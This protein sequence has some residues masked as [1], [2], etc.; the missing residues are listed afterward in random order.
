MTH[1]TLSSRLAGR[2]VALSQ[3]AIRVLQ[4]WKCAAKFLPAGCLGVMTAVSSAS[5]QDLTVAQIGPF[6]GLP[7][8][9]A[10]EINAGAQAFF[11]SVNAAGGIGGRNIKLLKF[12]DGFTA[13]GFIAQFKAAMD[14]G[15]IALLSPI[16]SA[17][18]SK[19]MQDGLLDSTD[20]V[21][22]NAI[23]GSE[24]FRNPGHPKLFHVRAGDR[25]Q[26]ERILGHAKVLSV[27]EMHVLHQDLPIG[28]GGL[29]TV[30]DLAARMGG[31]KVT[32]TGTKHD[33]EALTAAARDSAKV[34]ISS[35][36]IVIGTP[37]F[38]ADAI[39]R[40]RAAGGRHQVYT[41][42][43]VPAGLLTKVVGEAGARGVGIAQTFPA[44]QGSKLKLQRDFQ[45]T[46]QQYAPGVKD[47]THFHLEG[48]VSARVLVAGLRRAGPR[49]TASTLRTALR[50]MG[51]VSVGG[52]NVD[53]RKGNVGS[54]WVDI[55]VVS[56][57]GKLRY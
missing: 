11:D 2:F 24:Q 23:P 4:I 48:Y 43:Y 52:F 29:A 55:A 17:A 19:M 30:Q 3:R 7:S 25:A 5:A 56:E 18:L 41:L 44:P 49:P 37:K 45:Q 46:M 9:D 38:C 21:V 27:N 13:P 57:G 34:P 36:V 22:M 39:A 15:P 53:F 10:A 28:T 16:G 51:E 54:S 6:T 31:I 1:P 35:S 20:V 50:D 47:Y 8:P 40:W 42:S 26:L 14:A 33:P 12:D 32:A